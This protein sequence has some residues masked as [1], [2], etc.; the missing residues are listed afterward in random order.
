MFKLCLMYNLCL[1]MIHLNLPSSIDRTS[2]CNCV[3]ICLYVETRCVRIKDV[4]ETRC[5]RIKDVVVSKMC[6]YHT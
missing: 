1:M 5:V 3:E 4:V 6:S 2:R